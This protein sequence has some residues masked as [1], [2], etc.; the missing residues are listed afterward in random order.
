MCEFEPFNPFPVHQL[1]AT[2]EYFDDSVSLHQSEASNFMDV[3]E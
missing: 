3:E 2:E 1:T